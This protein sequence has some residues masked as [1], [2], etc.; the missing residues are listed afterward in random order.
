LN[1]RTV[2]ENTYFVPIEIFAF[3]SYILWD[4]PI[5]FKLVIYEMHFLDKRTP[6]EIAYHIPYSERHIRRVIREIKE[7]ISKHEVKKLSKLLGIHK[8][9][10]HRA[11]K[12]LKKHFPECLN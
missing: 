8:Q 4:F 10:A 7:L 3:D 11:G 6:K 5:K 9:S 2:K 12:K 1:E